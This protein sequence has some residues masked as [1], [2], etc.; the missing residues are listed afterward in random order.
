MALRRARRAHDI[1]PFTDLLF[2][3]LLGFTFMFMIAFM[4]M[5]P[6][7]KSGV[8]EAKAE[9]IITM[10]WPDGSPDDIDLWVQAPDGETVW[11][12]HPD[13]GLMH[14]D[15]DDRGQA[16]DQLLVDGRELINPLNEEVVTIRGII[17]GEYVVNV[18]YYAS[19]TQQPV[20]V[21]VR[22]VKVNP[23]L[24]VVYYGHVELQRLN[25]EATAV[26]FSVTADGQVARVNTLPKPLALSRSVID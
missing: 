21:E 14:L 11:F 13:A 18:H 16:N 7:A 6:K 1:D 25:Q 26:R 20:P 23:Q 10:N 17:P 3:A 12:K 15:R 19:Q 22:V 24:S 5:N 2:N 9:F 8:I 4:A